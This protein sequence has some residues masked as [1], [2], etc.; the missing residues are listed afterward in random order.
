VGDL[1]YAPGP[2]MGGRVTLEGDEARHLARVRRVGVGETVELFDGLG[3][4]ASGAVI[5]IGRDRV[6]IAIAD[7]RPGGRDLRGSLTLA[8]A[9]PKGERF[10]WLVE[11]ATELG[12]TRL[13]PLR[14]ERSVVDPRAA[15]L[16]RLRRVV[17]EA[18]KQSGR[19]RLMEIGEAASWDEWLRTGSG[20]ETRLIA[21][22]GGTGLGAI[23][24]EAGV[25]LAIGPEGGFTDGEV[26]AA[27][28][29]GYSAIGLGQTI[30]RIETAALAACAVVVA[31]PAVTS[32]GMSSFA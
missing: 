15:K 26:G 19:S 31:Q 25:V 24:L 20:A 1:F 12:V 23:R 18:C 16:E 29:A 30:L 13:V 8:T 27:K 17:V 3:N 6:E 7:I 10:D 9:V 11:K 4:V 32:T 5:E 28:S 14:T 21:H 22:P 2:W